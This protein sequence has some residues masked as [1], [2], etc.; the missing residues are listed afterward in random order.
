MGLE[1]KA[2]QYLN[3]HT[4]DPVFHWYLGRRVVK[5]VLERY[6]EPQLLPLSA[7]RAGIEPAIES[8]T[9][10]TFNRVLPKPLTS[11]L[12]PIPFRLPPLR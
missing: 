10:H 4:S 2:L 7:W 1:P 3:P 12:A 11:C 6:L 8:G 5:E 9:V